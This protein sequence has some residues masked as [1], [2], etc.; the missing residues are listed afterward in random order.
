MTHFMN[1]TIFIYFTILNS[2]TNESK[3]KKSNQKLIAH[4]GKKLSLNFQKLK[5]LLFSSYFRN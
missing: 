5:K 1:R 4:T 3:L 2:N